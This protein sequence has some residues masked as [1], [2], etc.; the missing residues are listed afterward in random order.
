MRI[1]NLQSD[2]SIAKEFENGADRN[3]SGETVERDSGGRDDFEGVEVHDRQ[4]GAAEKQK[5]QKEKKKGKGR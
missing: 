5:M 1:I 2:Y 3:A 4:A